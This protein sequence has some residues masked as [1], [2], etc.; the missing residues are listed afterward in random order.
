MKFIQETVKININS[1]NTQAKNDIEALVK[2]SEGEFDIQLEEIVQNIINQNKQII[3]L[4]GPSASGKTTTAKMLVKKLM[5]KGKKA[6]R[7]SLDNFYRNAENA[8]RWDNGRKNFETID[9]LD[10]IYLAE[11][12]REVE[13]NGISQ[14][15]VFDFLI[16]KRTEKTFDVTFEEDTILILE[17]LHALNPQISRHI[18]EKKCYKIYVSSHSEFVDDDMSSAMTTRDLR[19]I[20][21]CVRDYFH[22]GAS[23]EETFDFWVDVCN[24][25][26]L[27][28]RPFR[29]LCDYHINSTHE[30]EVYLYRKYILEIIDTSPKNKEYEETKK[31]LK[32]SVLSFEDIKVALLE[33]SLLKEFLPK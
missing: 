18:D 5:A 8:P 11:K 19:L 23:L 3:L 16:G 31:R 26:E 17:G 21:R 20:R 30:Y 15:P 10:V 12:L 32:E 2:K 29:T 4:A 24:G 28:I 1:T 25:E 7:I 9:A 27:Y 13:K 22:R 14:F 33:S 6:N